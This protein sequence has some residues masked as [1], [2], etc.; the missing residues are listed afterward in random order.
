MS[1]WLKIQ[2]CLTHKSCIKLSHQYKSFIKFQDWIIS[3]GEERHRFIPFK[4]TSYS[5]NSTIPSSPWFLFSREK[6]LDLSQA[7]EHNSTKLKKLFLIT[8]E[9]SPDIA[10]LSYSSEKAIMPLILHC[11]QDVVDKKFNHYYVTCKINFSLT[12]NNIVY[13]KKVFHPVQLYLTLGSSLPLTAAK[14]SVQQTWN[15]THRIENATD[16]TVCIIETQKMPGIKTIR[17]TQL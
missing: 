2:T 3:D 8:A 16:C 9:D 4:S 1:K 10:D 17:N 5:Y 14:S 7:C 11:I 13:R 15:T 12:W 6:T